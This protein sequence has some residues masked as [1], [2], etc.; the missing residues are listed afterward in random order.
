MCKKK[1]RLLKVGRTSVKKAL[2]FF[3]HDGSKI[4]VAESWDDVNDWEKGGVDCYLYPMDRL[5][6]AFRSS[7]SLRF[8]SWYKPERGCIVRQGARRV[9][10][11]YTDHKSVFVIK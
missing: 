2:G 11:E 3:W 4:Y 9:T 10:F 6:H 7:H 1:C 5:E 8:I